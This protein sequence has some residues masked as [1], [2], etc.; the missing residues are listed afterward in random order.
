MNFEHNAIPKHDTIDKVNLGGVNVVLSLRETL[1]KC[2]EFIQ[3]ESEKKIVRVKVLTHTD[4]Y[5][6]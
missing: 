3:Y 6:C 2:S 1:L 5:E 4:M